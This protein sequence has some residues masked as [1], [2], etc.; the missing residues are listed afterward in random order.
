M[1]LVRCVWFL[2]YFVD[3][4]NRSY[5]D[6]CVITGDLRYPEYKTSTV[7][8]LKNFVVLWKETST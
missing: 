2:S 1:H 4:G 7:I 6:Y 3:G 5:P 8:F